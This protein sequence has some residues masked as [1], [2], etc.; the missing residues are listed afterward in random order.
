MH[1]VPS[2][3]DILVELSKVDTL[4][5]ELVHSLLKVDFNNITLF[6]SL[7]NK[8]LMQEDK[9][10]DLGF[11]I[12]I[13][14]KHRL[15][16]KSLFSKAR[17]KVVYTQLQALAS[18]AKRRP[19]L[20]KVFFDKLNLLRI[21]HRETLLDKLI[22]LEEQ[23]TEYN[24]FQFTLNRL[25]KERRA[26]NF[27]PIQGLINI[28]IRFYIRF[29]L[30]TNNDALFRRLVRL[31]VVDKFLS[32]HKIFTLDLFTECLLHKGPDRQKIA[33]TILSKRYLRVDGLANILGE[34]YLHQA[35]KWDLATFI[36][37]LD[38]AVVIDNLKTLDVNGNDMYDVARNNNNARAMEAI[39]HKLQ[40]TPEAIKYIDAKG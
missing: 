8:Q 13:L 23:Q 26:Y 16:K 28:K 19:G 27:N 18:R 39:R 38:V 5:K 22:L 10:K 31:H 4:P 15:L 24:L 1:V 11:L 33:A 12:Q 35:A 6:E 14:A 20:I 3:K 36:R 34:T 25:A 2:D 9:I 32:E 21:K 7:L 17:H 29:V 30:K 37:C 40:H